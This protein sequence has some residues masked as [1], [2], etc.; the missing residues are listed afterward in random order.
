MVLWFLT[1]VNMV[2]PNYECVHMWGVSCSY[3][4]LSSSRLYTLVCVI[5][6]MKERE[7]DT[8]KV[9]VYILFR[10]TC[11]CG[12]D[13]WSHLGLKTPGNT[14]QVRH[15]ALR[16]RREKRGV[17]R[18][19]LLSP[20]SGQFFSSFYYSGIWTLMRVA[21]LKPAYMGNQAW[22]CT[23]GARGSWMMM[24]WCSGLCAWRSSTPLF[25]LKLVQHIK[26]PAV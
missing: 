16:S 6:W 17:D 21:G 3:L 12:S 5:V 10:P 14:P 11:C 25:V 1:I 9:R 22:N 24:N 18:A 15:S 19:F 23:G 13:P 20:I 4:D 7:G 2:L 26:D 8:G